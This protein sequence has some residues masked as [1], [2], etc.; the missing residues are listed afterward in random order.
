MVIGSL[1]EYLKPDCEVGS[2]AAQPPESIRSVHSAAL[3]RGFSTAPEPAVKSPGA[4]LPVLLWPQG[5]P[6]WFDLRF[7]GSAR[8]L[9][10]AKRPFR[11]G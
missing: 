9:A 6:E 3:P 7:I 5:N 11:P 8:S 1:S 2:G 10:R 4:V